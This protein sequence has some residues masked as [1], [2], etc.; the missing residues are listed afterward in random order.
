MAARAG[1]HV[2][3]GDMPAAV[4]EALSAAR[5]GQARLSTGVTGPVM[6]DLR[7]LYQ[8]AVN[9]PKGLEA[10]NRRHRRLG[11]PAGGGRP[12]QGR[13]PDH[14]RPRAA[15]GNLPATGGVQRP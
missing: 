1:G 2:L 10:E 4:L 13:V 6:E 12:A 3:K 15:D 9:R 8:A 14:G 7:E 5:Q 11:G